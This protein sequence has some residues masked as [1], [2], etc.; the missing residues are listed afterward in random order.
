[1]AQPK[2]IVVCAG[3][4]SGD[5]H[6]AHVVSE[7][8]RQ[9]PGVVVR[10]MAGANCAAAGMDVR[11]EY[12]DYAVIGF[13]G[14]L[15]SLPRFYQ[16]ERRLRAL[17]D[18]A[19]LFIPVDYPGLNLRLCAHARRR[20]KRVLYYIAPQ[21]WAWGAGRVER[22]RRSVD[23][24]AVVLPFETSIY[25]D[26]G[27]QAEFVGHPFLTDHELPEVPAGAARE[28]VALLPGSRT[29]EVDAMLPLFLDAAAV[30]RE[31]HAGLR[32]TVGR[33][34]VVNPRVYDEHVQRA[35]IDVEMGDGATPVLAQARTAMV[36]SGTATLES[37][38]LETPLVVAYRTGALN[39]ALARRL[40]KIPNVGL[41][42]VLLG[43]E[44]APEFVQEDATP[45]AM[46]NAVDEL[47][48]GGAKREEMLDRF[49][50][51]RR[52][53]AQGRGSERVA[54]IAGELLA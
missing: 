26:A 39:Y 54:E 18:D 23:R 43:E 19:D 1:M 51:L 17:I 6:A 52:R 35:G 25:Q 33:S 32:I 30:L 27:M 11:F 36:A 24:V 20:G 44:V 28:G 5:M 14:I 2:R 21:V 42:N 22:M 16:L 50:E 53:L 10:G 46:A 38:L 49:R 47:L 40:V 48:S 29:G 3:E 34:P 15:A 31:R 13:T 8:R 7:L 9:M 4:L 37:A 12:R 41:V 45:V